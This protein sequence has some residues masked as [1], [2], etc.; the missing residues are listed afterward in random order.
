MMPNDTP[1][2]GRPRKFGRPSQ[3]VTITLPDDVVEAFRAVH[4]DLS[5]AIVQVAETAGAKMVARPDVELTH[6]G[7]SAVIVLKPTRAIERLPGVALVPL[8]DR[9]ALISLDED[10]GIAEFEVLVRDA[11]DADITPPGDRATLQQLGDI[12]RSARRSRRVHVRRRSIIVLEAGTGEPAARRGA[13]QQGRRD[14][15]GD[16]DT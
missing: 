6:Y 5:R 12:L 13:A 11:L 8:P 7:R 16:R 3:T 15:T 14:T 10:K 9:R 2:R 4:S 1:R